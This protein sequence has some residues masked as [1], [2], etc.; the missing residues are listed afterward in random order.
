MKEK[1]SAV[2][3]LMRVPDVLLAAL[4]GFS[5]LSMAVSGPY[6]EFPDAALSLRRAL[7]PALCW[8]AALVLAAQGMQRFSESAPARFFRHPASVLL[9]FA[10]LFA[11][12]ALLAWCLQSNCGWDPQTLLT[13]ADSLVRG[14]PYDGV[15][16]HQYPNNRFLLSFFR[17]LFTAVN[18]L[19]STQYLYAAIL[20]GIAAVDLALLFLFGTVRR[21]WGMRAGWLALLMG[22]PLAGLSP[23][24]AVPYS[25]TYGMPFPIG[26]IY[27]YVCM[28]TG[29]TRRVRLLAAGGFAFLLAAGARVKPNVLVV[30]VAVG[31][32]EALRFFRARTSAKGMLR[33]AAC[34]ALGAVLAV[35]VTGA[36]QRKATGDML[37]PARVADE[38]LG[39]AHYFML[40]LAQPHGNYHYED[41]EYTM[42]FRGSAA[43]TQANLAEAGRRIRAMGPGGYLAFLGRKLNFCWN[44]GTFYFGHEGEFYRGDPPVQTPA[45][46]AVQS[47]YRAD[48]AHYGVLA[49]WQ[50]AQWLLCLGLVLAGAFTARRTRC[51]EYPWLARLCVLGLM[52]FLLLF[53]A[54]ARYVYHFLPV[55]CLAAMGG[56]LPLAAGRAGKQQA[57]CAPPA[58]H[59]K[60][61]TE[62]A[63]VYTD[64]RF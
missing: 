51:W 60:K 11:L 55:L 12:Q 4:L 9:F 44:D 14:E 50:Q 20:C 24:I 25:D 33:A 58:R 56:L 22:A 34:F 10:A 26:C 5:L 1:G 29:Q 16:F 46:R 7:V 30:A 48:G 37:D 28:R 49:V 42:S 8:L 53:E 15:Y 6:L 64:D 35:G 52:L 31:I 18:L 13:Q 17:F 62:N 63:P 47:L 23:W 41:M 2:W 43:K 19:G 36:V 40:G 39:M 3:A 57:A 59:A 54:R 27:C 61:G 21:L 32:G 38:K 45:A